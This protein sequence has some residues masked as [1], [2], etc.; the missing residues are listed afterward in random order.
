MVDKWKQALEGITNAI[1]NLMR[2]QQQFNST[3]IGS[4][5][6]GALMEQ[7]TSQIN[8]PFSKGVHIIL[9]QKQPRDL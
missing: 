4:L 6:N 8:K 2:R 1:N 9:Q 7:R 5:D 3:S